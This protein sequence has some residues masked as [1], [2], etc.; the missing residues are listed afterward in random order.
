LAGAVMPGGLLGG[1]KGDVVLTFG[2]RI[3]G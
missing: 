1:D 2:G 3:Y